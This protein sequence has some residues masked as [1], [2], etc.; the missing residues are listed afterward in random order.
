MLKDILMLDPVQNEP[1]KGSLYNKTV[2]YP[3]Y[4][5]EN[6]TE[7]LKSS[8]LFSGF[9]DSFVLKD[10]WPENNKNLTNCT[11]TMPYIRDVR[12]F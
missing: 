3:D 5:M 11:V 7:W 4:S 10:S 2:V 12:K 9:G 6:T 8:W 1:F